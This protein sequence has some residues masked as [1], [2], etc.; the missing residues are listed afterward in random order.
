MKVVF[1]KNIKKWLLAGMS[2]NIGPLN[3]TVIQLFIMA[4]GIAISLVVF[5]GLA[6]NG[7]KLLGI[8]FAIFI[9]VIFVI[10]TFFKISELGLLPFAVKLVRNNFFD[11]KKKYQVNYTKQDKIQ[12]LIEEE[13]EKKKQAKKVIEQKFNTIDKKTISDIDE[14]GLI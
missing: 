13:K 8:V 14:G 11:T 2:F 6:K 1:P 3:I 7:S 5:N 4:I 12:I 10:V 9:F